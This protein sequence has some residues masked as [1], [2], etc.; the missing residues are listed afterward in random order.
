[1]SFY[2]VFTIVLERHAH[3]IGYKLNY[4]LDIIS[5]NLIV[6]CLPKRGSVLTA[7]QKGNSVLG[8]QFLKHTKS[9]MQ[10]FCML[11]EFLP[12]DR[13]RLFDRPLQQNPF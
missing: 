2:P 10:E 4:I 1:M 3:Y 5:S 9:T 13:I 8:H 11:E 7:N 12:R 6:G